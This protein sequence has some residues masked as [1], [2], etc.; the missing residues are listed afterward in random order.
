LSA[1]KDARGRGPRTFRQENLDGQT[2]PFACSSTPKRHHDLGPPR[3]A[4]SEATTIELRDARPGMTSCFVDRPSHNLFRQLSPFRCAQHTEVCG[5]APRRYPNEGRCGT[6]ETAC[7]TVFRPGFSTRA[8]TWTCDPGSDGPPHG[9]PHPAFSDMHPPALLP[10]GRSSSRPLHE[11]EDRTCAHPASGI[12]RPTSSGLSPFVDICG[13]RSTPRYR[14]GRWSTRHR[15]LIAP[16]EQDDR[17]APSAEVALRRTSRDATGRSLRPDS[18]VVDKDFFARWFVRGIR[19]HIR[20][21]T[22]RA[23]IDPRG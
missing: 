13:R 21:L 1:A 23:L 9:A 20:A 4:F 8:F 11:G 22:N 7:C 2:E 18:G 14:A 3:I 6:P 12:P 15:A 5:G 19:W 10:G 17:F 16:H